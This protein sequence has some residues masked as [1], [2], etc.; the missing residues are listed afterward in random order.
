[1]LIESSAAYVSQ[2]TSKS[3]SAARSLLLAGPE[4]LLVISS[5]EGLGLFREN[6]LLG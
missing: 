5:R 1:M 6:F 4:L 2:S 3:D